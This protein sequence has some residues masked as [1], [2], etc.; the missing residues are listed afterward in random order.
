MGK[1]ARSSVALVAGLATACTG[2]V[3]KPP[4]ACG[5]LTAISVEGST[6]EYVAFKNIGTCA[7]LA[8]AHGNLL[9]TL[10]QGAEARILCRNVPFFGEKNPE[11]DIKA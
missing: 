5:D 8:D 1:I 4:E 11:S 9:G 10:A 7:L 6:N 3:P 2:G